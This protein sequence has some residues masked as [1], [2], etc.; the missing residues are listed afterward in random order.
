MAAIPGSFYPLGLAEISPAEWLDMCGIKD[1]G[2]SSVLAPVDIDDDVFV[3]MYNSR[4]LECPISASGEPVFNPEGEKYKE[5]YDKA[6]DIAKRRLKE[7][8]S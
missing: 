7:L 4:F 3:L 1:H 5:Y 8:V 2:V 6:L